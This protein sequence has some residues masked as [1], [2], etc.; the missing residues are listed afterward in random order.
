ML[1]RTWDFAQSTA[2]IRLAIKCPVPAT[3][4]FYIV[5]TKAHRKT[6]LDEVIPRHQICRHKNGEGQT[7][8][9]WSQ[10]RLPQI[11]W[12]TKYHIPENYFL[13]SEGKSKITYIYIYKYTHIYINTN[14]H[15]YTAMHAR[16]G[17]TR[18]VWS[19]DGMPR[20]FLLLS[21]DICID[22]SRVPPKNY[23]IK[24]PH[25]FSRGGDLCNRDS[26]N[27]LHLTAGISPPQQRAP[28]H[29]HKTGIC[30]TQFYQFK[31]GMDP[32][33]KPTAT[34]RREDWYLG[35]RITKPSPVQPQMEM[36]RASEAAP[37]HAPPQIKGEGSQWDLQLAWICNP[38]GLTVESDRKKF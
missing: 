4:L 13:M 32:S 11:K 22:L 36:K 29:V 1:H 28:Q 37:P 14:I 16:D 31:Y 10:T 7:A 30:S 33:L 8:S 26:S 35:R 5:V 20:Y 23:I 2:T 21:Q 6:S 34:N 12:Y 19:A 24:S 3:G 27:L 15:I 38:R 18:N 17:S 9:N 25:Q